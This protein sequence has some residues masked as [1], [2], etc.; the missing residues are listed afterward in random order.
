MAGALPPRPPRRGRFWSDHARVNLMALVGL[1]LL[2][3]C[4]IVSG[5]RP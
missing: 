4:C 1:A 2:L 3:A 5:D